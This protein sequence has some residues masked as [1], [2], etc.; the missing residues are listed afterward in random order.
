MD[1]GWNVVALDFII[2]IECILISAWFGLNFINKLL[3]SISVCFL[4]IS[5]GWALLLPGDI[6]MAI[7]Y[8]IN[9]FWFLT[10][11]W[12]DQPNRIL[13]SLGFGAFIFMLRFGNWK[14]YSGK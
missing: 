2:I 13:I 3:S 4:L 5:L 10:R 6:G 8:T 12:R 14:N 1:I 9:D 11:E 7:G